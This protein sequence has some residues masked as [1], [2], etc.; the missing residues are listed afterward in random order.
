[1]KKNSNALLVLIIALMLGFFFSQNLLPDNLPLIPST[2]TTPDLASATSAGTNIHFI[3]VGHGDAILICSGR[4]SVLIDGGNTDSGAIVVDYLTRLGISHLDA[5]IATHPHKEH[6]GGL[7]SV[8]ESVP[9]DAFYTSNAPVKTETYQKLMKTLTAKG[10]NPQ[11]PDIGEAISFDGSSATLTLLAPD[12]HDIDTIRSG[13]VASQSLVFRLDAD[14]CS[15]LFPGDAGI[16][17]E[18]VMVQQ[19][20]T[21]LDCD[22]LKVGSHGSNTS[23]SARFLEAVSP[24]YAVISF[25]ETEPP[26]FE[27]YQA[28]KRLHTVILQT[29]I[30]GT[31]VLHLEN[32][33]VQT[34]P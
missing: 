2:N 7:I 13:N 32:G 6:I 24:S 22:I 29:P 21:A 28:L 17:M 3:N 11:R 19:N 31:I 27:V 10:I 9:I 18:Q 14:G 33:I 8:L 26:D 1:M 15:A 25:G 20:A 5:V 23:S 16:R 30:N 4:S 12:P 34:V